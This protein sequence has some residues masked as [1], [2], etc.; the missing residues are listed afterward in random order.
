MEFQA[1]SEI[2]KI[3][4]NKYWRN[5]AKVDVTEFVYTQF[6]SFLPDL[7][8]DCLTDSI[9]N[10]PNPFKTFF[11]LDSMFTSMSYDTNKRALTLL[12]FASRY[13][14]PFIENTL[15]LQGMFENSRK[16][17]KILRI[18]TPI[19]IIGIGG[20]GFNILNILWRLVRQGLVK[21]EAPITVYENDKLEI[22][23]IPRLPLKYIPENLKKISAARYLDE[24]LPI[25][26]YEEY[27]TPDKY[28]G[29]S[30][31]IGAPNIRTRRQI[32][33]N[34]LP[35]VFI[36]YQNNVMKID[37]RKERSQAALHETYG[38]TDVGKLMFQLV[39]VT[40]LLDRII[41]R[42]NK[43]KL[44]LEFNEYS[45]VTLTDKSGFRYIFP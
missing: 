28:D 6:D 24:Y 1:H 22:T 42:A 33:D 29:E 13:S 35:Y 18:T 15:G 4:R 16:L 8:L 41:E 17:P 39:V 34:K 40:S 20:V 45:S 21:I 2:I 19:T 38:K 27:W 14:K 5:N 32:I 3:F 44:F 7:V 25:K 23:N 30:I 12:Y 11:L 9:I 36:V 10:A 37:S 31:L 43:E 26:F